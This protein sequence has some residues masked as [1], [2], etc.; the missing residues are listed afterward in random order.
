M[1]SPAICGRQTR[2]SPLAR[3]RPAIS[4]SWLRGQPSSQPPYC[5]STSRCHTPANTP[6]SS[7]YSRSARPSVLTPLAGAAAAQ[8]GSQCECHRSR[9]QTVADRDLR[10]AHPA[11]V[12]ALQA[13]DPE[14]EIFRRVGGVRVHPGD[15]AAA[16]VT[17]GDVEPARC[18]STR[19]VEHAQSGIAAS[20]SARIERVPSVEPPSTNRNSSRPETAAQASRPRCRGCDALHSAPAP[21]R[22]SRPGP[23]RRLSVVRAACLHRVS[24]YGEPRLGPRVACHSTAQ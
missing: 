15:P 10:P 16:R 4:E 6:E 24:Q 7:S 19:I 14:R 3:K 1:Y 13:L 2:R 11:C 17:E 5:S 8:R 21:A 18:A 9:D 12:T 22:S 23:G 20:R